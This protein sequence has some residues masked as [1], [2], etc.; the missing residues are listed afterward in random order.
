M[1]NK[2][3]VTYGDVGLQRDVFNTDNRPPIFSKQC[4]FM[5][6]SFGTYSSCLNDGLKRNPYR[7]SQIVATDNPIYTINP[8]YNSQ[9]KL[10]S[11][12]K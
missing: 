8:K 7:I 6:S 2:I 9:I 10:N 5:N 1:K 3:G 4:F 12:R 11:H